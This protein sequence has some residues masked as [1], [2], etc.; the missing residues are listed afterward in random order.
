HF[1]K[2]PKCPSDENS[3]LVDIKVGGVLC[4]FLI[5]SGS[6]CNVIDKSCWEKLKAKQIKCKSEKTATQIYSYGSSK[7]LIVAGKFT[8]DV[9]CQGK[10]VKEAEFIVIEGTGKPLLG[11]K[12]AIQLNVLKIGPQPVISEGV[13]SVEDDNTFRD[14]MMKTYS[15]C[16]KG[17]GKLKDRQLEVNLDPNV[18]PVA[19]RARNIPYGLQSKVEKKLDELERQGIIEKVK[20]PA[21]WASP[22]VV[23][24]KPNGDIRL[25][26]DMRRAN[27]AIVREK[28]PIPTVDDILHEI[29]GSKVFSKLDLKYGYHQLELEEKSREI[30]TTVTHK[31]HYRYTRLI[32]GM[33]NASEYYQYH[34]GDAIRDCEGVHNISDD[35]I[36]HGKDQA[37]HDE[38]LEKLLMTLVE[39]NLTLNPEKCQFRMTELTFMGYLLSERGIGPTNTKVEAVKNARR[40]ETAS[41]V[42]SFLGLVNFS[43]RFIPDLATTSEPLRQLTRKGVVF[44]W[45]K[46]HENA[47][48]KLKSQLTN[49][50][51]LAY[52][53]KDAK[54][55]IIADASPVGLGAVLIQEQDG[56]DRVVSYASRSLTSVERRYSQTEKEALGLV[57]ACERFHVY[58]YGSKFEL[59][60]DHKPLEV[61]YSKNSTPPAR[62]QRWVLRLQSYDFTVTYRPGAQNI[63]DALSRLTMNTSPSTD[64]AEDYIRFVAKNAVPNAITIQEVEKESDKDPELSKVRSCILTDDQWESV[65]VAYRSVRQELSVLGKWCNYLLVQNQC[66]IDYYSRWIEIDILKS[67]T[68]SK[69]V[70]S[71]DRMFLTH[72]LPSYRTTP[73]GT[74]GKA[75]DEMLF[76][77]RLRTKIPE[78]V[79][80]DKCDEEFNAISRKPAQIRNEC[81]FGGMSYRTVSCRSWCKS[82]FPRENKMF[83]VKCHFAYNP[84]N[85]SLLPCQEAGLAFGKNEILHV[86]DRTDTWWWQAR[87]ERRL[88]KANLEKALKN[89]CLHSKKYENI[90]STMAKRKKFKKTKIMYS[91]NYTNDFETVS[92]L[93]YEEVIQLTPSS[94]IPRPVVLVGPRLV[95]RNELRRLL[96]S[97]DPER[98]ITPVNY[99]SRKQLDDE[100]NNFFY[101]DSEN[102]RTS[103]NTRRSFTTEHNGDFERILIESVRTLMNSGKCCVI[104]VPPQE[105]AIVRTRELLPYVIFVKPPSLQRLRQTRLMSRV[106]SSSLQNHNQKVFTVTE[107][108]CN[109]RKH[110]TRATRIPNHRLTHD[111][112]CSVGR[113]IITINEEVTHRAPATLITTSEDVQRCG[114]QEFA[115]SGIFLDKLQPR[116][117]DE[118]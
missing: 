2:S 107:L 5:D 103:S 34:I 86:F 66:I 40:P 9:V 12:T 55:K 65:D 100:N 98:F 82:T 111:D 72:G 39:K 71:L 104:V 46:V 117:L 30:T 95:G 47:F 20:G 59:I 53:D 13:N 62:I 106:K 18:K 97:S 78:L 68:S 94:D 8:A 99:P 87:K 80:F 84:R 28:F 118:R 113:E 15:G 102:C 90:F 45:T 7:P 6:T 64:D 63:A 36:V 77:R 49:A 108:I 44:Q 96:I 92:I 21:K 41:E 70:Q 93:A 48:N 91:S 17:I 75:P 58:L 109:W 26:T 31:G 73:H 27:E 32:F 38:R 33:N 67:I 105:L 114:R 88:Y 89:K 24:P 76:K 56:E 23:V 42:R 43:A 16:F 52:F 3:G 85:D 83:Y 69:I 14:R 112:I 79:P 74:T 115:T 116:V 110:V 29:N 54:T 22:L 11:K 37:E 1:A 101:T 35:I 10:E 81:L 19:Q 61:I 57:W 4:N 50:E 51:S 25:C 60:T